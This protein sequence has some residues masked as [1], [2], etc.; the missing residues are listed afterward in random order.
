MRC[1]PTQTNLA[2]SQILSH[3]AFMPYRLLNFS[4][5]YIHDSYFKYV[6]HNEL[7]WTQL[8]YIF[9]MSHDTSAEGWGGWGKEWSLNPTID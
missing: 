4:I 1:N 5:I 6:L 9:C 8:G 2:K 7:L 3:I